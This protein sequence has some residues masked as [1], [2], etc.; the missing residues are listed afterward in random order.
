MRAVAGEEGEGC[1]ERCSAR[2]GIQGRR[3]VHGNKIALLEDGDTVGQELDFGESVRSE[4]K[5]CTLVLEDFGFQEVAE[6]SGSEGIETPGGFIEEQDFGLVQECAEEAEALDGARGEGTHLP[7]ESAGQFEAFGKG[8][9]AR[10]EER[11]GEMIQ[12]AEETQVFAAR[13]ARVEA[14]VGTR[15]VAQLAADRSGLADAIESGNHGGAARGQEKCGENAKQRGF[16]GA[17][18]AEESYR[19]AWFDPQGNPTKRRGARG[20]KRLQEGAPATVG[21]WKEFFQGIDSDRGI[22]HSRVY[23]VSGE[24]KQ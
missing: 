9:N 11:I 12:T 10:T 3:R 4:K 20:G 15:V 7:V 21:E 16:S 13:E 17:V 2:P 19:F 24:R 1:L 23:N 5:R 14:Q 6:V 8:G 22:G 18:G